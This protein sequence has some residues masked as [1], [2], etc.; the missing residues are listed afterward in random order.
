MAELADQLRFASRGAL[1]RQIAH[2]ETLAAELEESE[3]Y[4]EDWIVYR[5]TGHRPEAS[6]AA[7]TYAGASVLS[8]LSAFVERLC[9]AAQLER[10]DIEGPTIDAVSLC[11]RWRVSRKTVDRARRRGLIARRVRNER[12]RATLVFTERAVEAY[13]RRRG[14]ALERAGRFSRLG[15][16]MEAKIIRRAARYRE[17]FNCSLNRA[18]VRLAERFGRSH[19]GIRELLE[20]HDARQREL[21]L[22][23]IFDERP[24]RSARTMVSALRM[25]RAGAEPSE[26][27]SHIFGPRAD[28]RRATRLIRQ[29]RARLLMRLELDGPVSRVFLRD[30][31]DEVLLAPEA[32]RTRLGGGPGA[33]ELVEMIRL[34]R[35]A[36]PPE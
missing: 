6:G 33:G 1:L 2:A 35:E 28:K 11:A 25:A 20:R 17:R 9:D 7:V 21:G 30:D 19:Q 23:P 36:P 26:I 24:D 27:A 5:I 4:P 12:G 13:E 32:V 22:E 10:G 29:I 18:A 34:I 14:D 31:A 15:P 8:D 16:D 3:Q